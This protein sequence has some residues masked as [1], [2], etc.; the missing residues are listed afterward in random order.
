MRTHVKARNLDLT[1][2]LRAQ[3]DRKLQRLE[4]ITHPDADATVELIATRRG[5]PRPRTWPR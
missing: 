3:I 5:P 1:E 2:R 4:R